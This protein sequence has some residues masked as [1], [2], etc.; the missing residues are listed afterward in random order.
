MTI[1]MLADKTKTIAHDYGV[2]VEDGEDQGLTYRATFIIDGEGILRHYSI[3]DLPVG[4][5]VD[6]VLRLVEAFNYSDVHGVVC[7]VAWKPGKR[8]LT[9]H[10]DTTNKVYWE[11]DHD[12][13]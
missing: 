1:P 4:R 3:N 2:V 13:K 5:N 11:K 10:D 9:P 6:E 8:T 7:P 12:K